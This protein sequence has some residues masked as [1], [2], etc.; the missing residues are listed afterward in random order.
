MLPLRTALQCKVATDIFQMWKIVTERLMDVPKS[1][2]V[3]EK[4]K[5]ESQPRSLALRR[6]PVPVTKLLRDLQSCGRVK[7]I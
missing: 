7:A 4:P 6:T 5:P 3:R 2:R 1:L